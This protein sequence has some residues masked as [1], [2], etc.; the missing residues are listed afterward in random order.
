ML[1]KPG[2]DTYIDDRPSCTKEEAVAKLIGWMRGKIRLYHM[3]LDKFGAYVPEQLPYLHTLE[4]TVLGVLHDQHSAALAAL[5]FA[6]AS[7]EGDRA[8]EGWRKAVADYEKQRVAAARYSEELD[9]EI[10]RVPSELVLDYAAMDEKGG[11][12]ITLDSLDKW[13]SKKGIAIS[14]LSDTKLEDVPQVEV[15]GRLVRREMQQKGWLTPALADNLH[16]TL[17][18]AIVALARE[19]SVY[20]TADSQVNVDGIATE[21]E[22]IAEQETAEYDDPEDRLVGQKARAIT[23]RI[24]SALSRLHSNRP[25]QRRKS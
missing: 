17:A 14:V 20:R 10:A 11:I 7:G 8:I 2:P 13:A 22:A 19:R 24:N 9:V 3:D 25:G 21:L 6:E 1:L 16:V 18:L 15:E 23:S 5:R 12:H 4:G